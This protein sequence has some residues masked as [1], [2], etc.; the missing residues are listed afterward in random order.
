[1]MTALPKDQVFD[2]AASALIGAGYTVEEANPIALTTARRTFKNVWDL[3]LRLNV[4]TAD[5]SSRVIVSGTYWVTCCGMLKL[6]NQPV[7]GGHGGVKGKMWDELQV[8]A[9]SIRSAVTAIP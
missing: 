1:M 8:A 3:Q 9:D 4:L 7:E 2:R 5:D 6:D